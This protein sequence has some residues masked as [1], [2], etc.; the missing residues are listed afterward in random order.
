L[1]ELGIQHL[2]EEFPRLHFRST[3]LLL[4]PFSFYAKKGG[5]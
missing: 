1:H 4:V 5:M 2:R 3:W